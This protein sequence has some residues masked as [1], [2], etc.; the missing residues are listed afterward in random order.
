VTDRKF[1]SVPREGE[2]V[3]VVTTSGIRRARVS[4][5]AWTAD[6]GIE[7][8]VRFLDDTAGVYY[9]DM[10]RFVQVEEANGIMDT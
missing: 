5:D 8:P 2:L 4:G 10:L 9:L 1:K 6:L 3:D 7:V